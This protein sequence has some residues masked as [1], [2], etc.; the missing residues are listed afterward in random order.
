M[1][2]GHAHGLTGVEEVAAGDSPIH[3]LD[4]RAKIIGLIGVVLVTVST[5]EGAWPAFAAYGVLLLALWAI[6]RLPLGHVLRRM[7]IETPFLIAAG[8]LVLVR[9]PVAGGTLA[10]RITLSVLA[11]ILLSSSTP[12]PDLLRGFQRLRAPALI[13]MIVAFMWRYLHVIGDELRRMRI[14][15][16]AR[17]WRPR[18]LWQARGAIGATIAALFIRSLERGERVHLAMTSR[19]YAGGVPSGMVVPLTL[20]RADLAFVAGLAAWLA[21][22]RVVLG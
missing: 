16:E 2:R 6:A 3:R 7:V 1:S 13:V 22:V 19:G 18:T 8:F 10:V 4:P 17:G 21:S 20:R 14:A 12:F 9:G 15:R 5:P 11:V